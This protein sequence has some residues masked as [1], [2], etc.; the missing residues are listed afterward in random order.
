MRPSKR[1]CCTRTHMRSSYF[2]LTIA[3]ILLMLMP[4]ALRADNVPTATNGIVDDSDAG[5]TWSGFVEYDDP[6]LHG[7]T[8]HAGGPGSYAVYTFHGTGVEVYAMRGPSIDI[9]GRRHRMGTMQVSIDD[10]VKGDPSVQ[11]DSD[12]YDFQAFTAD[13]LPDGNHVLKIDPKGGWVVIDYIRV[14]TGGQT[15]DQA[16]DSSKPK[17]DVVGPPVVIPAGDYRLYPRIS[18]SSD[19]DDKDWLTTDGNPLQIWANQPDKRQNQWF[20]VTPLGQGKYWMAPLVA[21]SEAVTMLEPDNDGVIHAGIWHNIENPAQVWVI[22]DTGDGWCRLSP[23]CA[24]NLALT[25]SG[26]HNADGTPVVCEVWRA[27]PSQE[28]AV[29]IK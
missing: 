21:T 12:D 25:V 26:A 16:D 8:G 17:A 28:W 18:P 13:G 20:H 29:G 7:G 27:D 9:D 1:S 19:L 6:E 5:W 14:H 3:A 23:S 22:T 4:P 24:T 15:V 2:V 10:Q 11:Y